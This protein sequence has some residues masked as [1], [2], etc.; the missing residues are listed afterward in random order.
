M[1]LSKDN[2][3]KLADLGL[4]KLIQSTA[5]KTY[6]GTLQYMSPEIFHSLFESTPYFSNTDVWFVFPIVF[7]LFSSDLF[8]KVID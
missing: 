1:L 3:I 5:C 2:I 8:Y 6:A 7:N 4:A